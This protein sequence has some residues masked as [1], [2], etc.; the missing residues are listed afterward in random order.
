MLIKTCL[1]FL[2]FQSIYTAKSQI[3]KGNWMVGGNA[4]FITEH[5]TSQSLNLDNKTLIIQASPDI[6]YFFADKFAAGLKMNINSSRTTYT[7]NGSPSTNRASAYGISPFARYYFLPAKNERVNLFAETDY[8]YSHSFTTSDS[9]SGILIS[10][11]PV[12]YFN[13]SVGI[14]FTLNYQYMSEAKLKPAT[15]AFFVGVGLQVHLIK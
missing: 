2:A 15:N 12:I 5:E 10:A 3:T 7:V 6:G 13:S 9:Q 14:E 11:G 4:G 8:Q 1:I